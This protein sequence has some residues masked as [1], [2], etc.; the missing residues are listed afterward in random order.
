M[1]VFLIFLWN[2]ICVAK[3]W[4]WLL[5]F[6]G[7]VFELTL[8]IFGFTIN[9]EVFSKEQSQCRKMI[10]ECNRDYLYFGA[11]ARRCDPGCAKNPVSTIKGIHEHNLFAD[12]IDN[13]ISSRPLTEITIEGSDYP[14]PAKSTK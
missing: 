6:Y 13:Y 3:K 10:R 2:L 8:L 14:R 11:N 12:M 7:T 4:V 5:I 9:F 1:K